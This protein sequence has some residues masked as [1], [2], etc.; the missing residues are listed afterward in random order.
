[1]SLGVT[2]WI[3]AL[4]D[5]SVGYFS[6]DYDGVAQ[7]RW[8]Q[9]SPWIADGRPRAIRSRHLCLTSGPDRVREAARRRE[10]Q[11]AAGSRGLLCLYRI[12]ARVLRQV[13]GR[14][15]LASFRGFLRE[16]GFSAWAAAS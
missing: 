9:L 3:F 4:S 15:L 8:W 7:L 14:H 1:M 2:E 12:G 6:V 10:V 16:G 5:G 11:T 13:L